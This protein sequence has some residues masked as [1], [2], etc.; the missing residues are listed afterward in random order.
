[1]LR[2]LAHLIEEE[3][4]WQVDDLARRLHTSP[5]LV[6][7]MLDTLERQ[8]KIRPMAPTC[9]INSSCATCPLRSVC[10]APTAMTK[11]WVQKTSRNE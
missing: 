7:A 10:S 11:V 9:G 3:D 5:A 2:E 6:R 1:M 4:V 8:G